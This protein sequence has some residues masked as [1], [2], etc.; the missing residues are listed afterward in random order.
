MPLFLMQECWVLVSS[1]T[2]HFCNWLA[3]LFQW[4]PCMV[5]LLIKPTKN[6]FIFQLQN[7]SFN[8]LQMFLFE[9]LTIKL[10]QL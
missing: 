7:V 8:S 6:D 3:L 4:L 5:L 10:A 2:L 9:K 1:S